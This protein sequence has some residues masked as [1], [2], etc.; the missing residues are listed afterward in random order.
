MVS[1]DMSGAAPPAA[2]LSRLRLCQIGSS[3][4]FGVQ[5]TASTCSDRFR[6]VVAATGCSARALFAPLKCA[7]LRRHSK[8][9]RKMPDSLN[10]VCEPMLLRDSGDS[11]CEQPFNNKA[12]QI[13]TANQSE[14]AR[15]CS[16]RRSEGGSDLSKRDEA[17]G[18]SWG[19]KLPTCLW[20]P[21]TKLL[22]S[23]LFEP[24][25]ISSLNVF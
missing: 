12:H 10:C 22:S 24:A 15:W 1:L 16:A 4:A 7:S 6:F 17:Q 19:L 21:K 20:Q 8:E 9:C 2:P 13:A 3:Q 23:G 18:G 25:N 14:R 5:S 11:A